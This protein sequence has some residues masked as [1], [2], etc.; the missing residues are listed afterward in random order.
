MHVLVALAVVLAVATPV[1]VRAMP[2]PLDMT[3]AAQHEPC[4]NCPDPS[5]SGTTSPGKMLACPLLAC[6]RAPATLPNPVLVP[7]GVAFRVTYQVPAASRWSESSPAPDPF[8]PRPTVL[9]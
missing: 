7:E 8:P 2:M 4:Q 1:G 9:R 3:G 6:V 5:Q